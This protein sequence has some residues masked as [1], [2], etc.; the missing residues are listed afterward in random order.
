M[1][2][3]RGSEIF[4]LLADTDSLQPIAHNYAHVRD[5]VACLA[6]QAS[7]QQCV[8]CNTVQYKDCCTVVH[9]GSK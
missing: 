4:M 2:P 1:C 5:I 6:S 8:Q 9:T 7:T 3:V